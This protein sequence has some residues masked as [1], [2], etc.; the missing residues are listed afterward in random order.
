MSFGKTVFSRRLKS[1]FSKLGCP[2]ANAH[3]NAKLGHTPYQ[4]FSTR[5]KASL[6]ASGIL[7]N[8]N[9]CG[10]T[11]SLYTY[12]SYFPSFGHAAVETAKK[13]EMSLTLI[14]SLISRGISLKSGLGSLQIV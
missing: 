6:Y 12:M 3:A 7:I 10:F 5:V 1:K 2:I 13:Q 8:R 9:Y 11:S 14:D 4:S